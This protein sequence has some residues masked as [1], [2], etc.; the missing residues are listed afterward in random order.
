MSQV[1]QW[2]RIHLP[3]QETEETQVQLWVGKIP[4]SRKW[5]LTPVFSPGKFHGQRSLAGYSPWGPKESDMTEST[6]TQGYIKPQI[7]MAI[8][9]GR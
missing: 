7:Q 9:G 8:L 6:Y 1:V 5:Q 3:I 4:W 2:Q